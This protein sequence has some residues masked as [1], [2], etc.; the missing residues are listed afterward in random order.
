MDTFLGAPGAPDAFDEHFDWWGGGS[1]TPAPGK[2]S[3]GEP[4]TEMQLIEKLEPT[5]LTLEV[6]ATGLVFNQLEQAAVLL[7]LGSFAGT[8]R[9]TDLALLLAFLRA[10]QATGAPRPRPPAEPTPPRMLDFL[11]RL[12]AVPLKVRPAPPGKGADVH[13]VA[14]ASLF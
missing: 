14:D 4:A 7:K 1:G 2:P 9:A 10:W 6:R 8:T 11:G 13:A 12:L 3:L 5:V